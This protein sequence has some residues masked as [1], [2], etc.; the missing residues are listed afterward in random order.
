MIK[1]NI[2]S[3][4]TK[5]NSMLVGDTHFI[6][7]YSKRS[8]VEEIQTGDPV[9]LIDECGL[10]IAD[11]TSSEIEAIGIALND[12]PKDTQESV[13]VIVFGQVKK[14]EVNLLEDPQLWQAVVK[15]LRHNGV[16]LV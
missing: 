1:G 12:S 13:S 2:A 11:G 14:S 16:Y 6:H 8:D 9:G 5:Q 3:I 15:S 7:T 10:T 4:D